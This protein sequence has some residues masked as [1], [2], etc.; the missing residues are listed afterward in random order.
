MS[1]KVIEVEALGKQYMRGMSVGAGDLRDAL[2]GGAQ[3]LLRG[4]RRSAASGDDDR[5]ARLFW[6]LRDVSFSV[7]RGEVFGIIGRNGAGKSTLLKV[8]TRVSPPTEGHA[9]MVGRIGALLEVGTGF[10]PEL[11][12]RENTYLNGAIL[13]MT[14]NEIDLA[15]PSIVEY[16][17]IEAFMD[18]PVKRFSSGMRVRL[19]FAIAAHLMPEILILDEVL[20]VGDVE[21]QRKSSQTI[22]EYAES[23]NTI[24]FVSHNMESVRN[25]CSRVM[26]LE[27]GQVRFVGSPEDAI[28]MYQDSMRPEAGAGLLERERGSGL[29]PVIASIGFRAASGEQQVSF[30]SCAAVTIEIGIDNA[31]TLTEPYVEFVIM[32]ALGTRIALVSSRVQKPDLG[33]LP[34]RGTIAF[35]FE[36]L[37]LLPGNYFVNVEVGNAGHRLDFLLRAAELHIEWADVFG[38]GILQASGRGPVVLAA[39]IHALP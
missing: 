25:I 28:R 23:G 14:R 13:G 34:P 7:A 30:P 27:Q 6:A 9:R 22:I 3:R 20:A 39:H 12:G 8:L 37:P 5:A 1:R 32:D 36:T 11:S 15:Y 10:H 38:T 17:G 2:T 29:E 19:G 31:E 26:F 18:T 33:P 4:F 35:E 21:F 24:L 16:A